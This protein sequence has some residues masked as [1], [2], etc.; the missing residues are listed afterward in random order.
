MKKAL[1]LA[2]TFAGYLGAVVTAIAIVGRFYG[3][4]PVFGWCASNLM[5][6]GATILV[7]ACWCKLES[8]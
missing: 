5:L 2:G 6:L 1:K 3:E 7:F 8:A 4:P